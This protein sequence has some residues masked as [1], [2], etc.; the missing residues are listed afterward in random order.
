ML[1]DPVTTVEPRAT[2]SPMRPSGFPLTKTVDNPSTRTDACVSGMI[3]DSH[4]LIG[5]GFKLELILR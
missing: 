3:R 5:R 4:R 2:G 1:S